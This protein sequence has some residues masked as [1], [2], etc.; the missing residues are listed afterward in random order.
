MT[1]RTLQTVVCFSLPFAL[2]GFDTLQPAGEYRVDH[3]EELIDGVSRLA[4]RRIGSFIHLPAIALHGSTQ[5]MVPI[6]PAYLDAALEKD[7]KTS[8][9]L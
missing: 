7:R 9:P 3:D 5:Q 4:W 1:S 6:S 8:C 2:P